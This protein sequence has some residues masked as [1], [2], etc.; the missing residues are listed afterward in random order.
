MLLYYATLLPNVVMS[1]NSFVRASVFSSV[2]ILPILC[3]AVSY[4]DVPLVRAC[5]C[6]RVFGRG[7]FFK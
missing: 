2:I 3:S 4:T 5:V 6:A 1:T 7:V